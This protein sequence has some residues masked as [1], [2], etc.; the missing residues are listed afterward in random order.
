MNARAQVTVVVRRRQGILFPEIGSCFRQHVEDVEVA[1]A[2]RLSRVTAKKSE[3]GKCI[4]SW[5]TYLTHNAYLFE[6]VVE[7][8]AAADHLGAI[9]IDLARENLL[10]VT[11]ITVTI[12]TTKTVVIACCCRDY[13]CDKGIVQHLY[14]FP[15]ATRVVVPNGFGISKGFQNRVGFQHLDRFHS[16]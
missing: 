4:T 6:Q 10:L 1:L 3:I 14:E 9:E 8:P 15:E 11:V 12:V 16:A 2:R 7:C 13:G 5:T